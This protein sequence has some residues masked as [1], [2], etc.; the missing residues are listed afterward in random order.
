MF[1][2]PPA[3]FQL[4]DPFSLRRIS[5]NRPAPLP[6]PRED[7]RE[8]EES[9]R[10]AQTPLVP[11]SSQDSSS[12]H[13][14]APQPVKPEFDGDVNPVTGEKGGPKREPVK[15]WSADPGGDWSFKGRVSDFWR[16][17]SLKSFSCQWT[18]ATVKKKKKK[19]EIIRI[20]GARNYITSQRNRSFP[21][22]HFGRKHK[23]WVIFKWFSHLTP[24][25]TWGQSPDGREIVFR[26]IR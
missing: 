18:H 13:P 12:S 25:R 9:Q 8:F 1:R 24:M 22:C 14:D 17:S 3:S 6:L 16:D 2:R 26:Y 21:T 19:H 23:S 15:R 4:L 20:T 5:L 11:S 7:Q 10:R